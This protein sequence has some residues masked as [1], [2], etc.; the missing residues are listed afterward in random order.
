MS[1]NAPSKIDADANQFRHQPRCKV[2]SLV[3]RFTSKDLVNILKRSLQVLW[4][5]ICQIL[6]CSDT[7]VRNIRP[8][9][10]SK[11]SNSTTELK[12]PVMVKG[13]TGIAGIPSGIEAMLFSCSLNERNE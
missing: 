8:I 13:I 4:P 6:G 2:D 7:F 10:D 5:S 3:Y 1:H 12:G 11:L 9:L